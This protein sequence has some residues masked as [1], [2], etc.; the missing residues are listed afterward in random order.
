MLQKKPDKFKVMTLH[1]I[2]LYEPDFNQNNKKL[3]CNMMYNAEQLKTL[4][5]KQFESR[6]ALLVVD[7][8]LNKVLTFDI[9]QQLKQPGALTAMDLKS[10]YDHIVHSFTK[11]AM[12]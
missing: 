1:T 5:V 6:K 12:E 11:I 7:H 4:A 8:A 3:G 2:L 9:W 10:C